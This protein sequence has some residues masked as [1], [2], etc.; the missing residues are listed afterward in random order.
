MKY[1]KYFESYNSSEVKS[2][3]LSAEQTT[4]LNKKSLEYLID[5]SDSEKLKLKSDLEKFARDNGYTLSELEDPEL[6]QRLIQPNTNEGLG[7]W[8]KDNWYN[9]V[10]KVAKYTGIASLITFVGSMS[11]YWF[12]GYDTLDGVKIAATAWIIS[13]IVSALKGLK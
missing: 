5:L 11:L 2:S 3:D 8:I 7:D 13:S 10:T 9:L 12:G 4:E 1:L 6:V